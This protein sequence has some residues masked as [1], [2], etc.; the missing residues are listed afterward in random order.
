MLGCRQANLRMRLSVWGLQRTRLVL[1]ILNSW[2][3][4]AMRTSCPVSMANRF[5]CSLSGAPACR[6]NESR[7]R[8]GQAKLESHG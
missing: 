3:D 7:A 6:R 4:H 8:D 1:R 2:S 5:R